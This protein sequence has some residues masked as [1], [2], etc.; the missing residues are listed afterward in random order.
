MRTA[1]IRRLIRRRR[2]KDQPSVKIGSGYDIFLNTCDEKCAKV[3]VCRLFFL[4]TL[5]LGEDS[6]K[7]WTKECDTVNEDLRFD[8]SPTPDIENTPSALVPKYTTSHKK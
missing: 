7:R 2:R 6:F 8:N 4:N 5:S 3:R 1:A